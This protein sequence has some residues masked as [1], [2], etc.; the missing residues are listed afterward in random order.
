MA[1]SGQS[2][3]RHGI[4]SRHVGAGC[5][6]GCAVHALALRLNAGGVLH[7]HRTATTH[8][9]HEAR[10]ST[11]EP[12]GEQREVKREE[13]AA[14][15][16]GGEEGPPSGPPSCTGPPDPFDWFT[17][18]RRTRRYRG[19]RPTTAQAHT[20]RPTTTTTTTSC[21]VLLLLRVVSRVTKS[22][23]WCEKLCS[24]HVPLEVNKSMRAGL[25]I[26]RL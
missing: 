7:R 1:M 26:Y 8:Q 2:S 25:F 9:L 17:W 5:C 3:H 18:T 12:Q 16:G 22:P 11:E 10:S 13:G 14:S 15:H 24:V 21:G 4:N 23:G 6:S 19:H 20:H